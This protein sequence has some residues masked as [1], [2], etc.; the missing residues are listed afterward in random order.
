MRGTEFS[1]S[2][3]RILAI[4]QGL[5]GER[6]AENIT[7]TAPSDWIVETWSAPRLLPPIID[8]PE[9]FLPESFPPHDL[10]LSLGEVGGLIQLIPD[11]V[12]MCDAQAVIAPID[13]NEAVPTGLARQLE[14]W[15]GDMGIPV[16]LPKPFCSLTETTYNRTP[17]VRE[18]NDPLIRRFATHYGKPEFRITVEDKKIVEAEVVRD[19]ACGCVAHVAE[20]ILGTDVDTAVEEAGMLHHHFPCLASMNK[21]VDYRDTLM[22]VSGNIIQ[23]ALKDEIRSHLT[24]VYLRP[25]GLSEE[26]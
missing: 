13:R 24:V 21:D 10:I 20:R 26:E 19:A 18:Y 3:F 5:W 25:G 16:V 14:G 2:P 7:A 23:D 4:T 17:L 15:L 9:E 11:I 1:D 8:D 6:I 12:R 22:H